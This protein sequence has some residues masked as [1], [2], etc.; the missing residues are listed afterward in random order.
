MKL[1]VFKFGG[2]AVQDAAHIINTASILKQ[3]EGENQ[4]VVI[5]AMGKMTNAFE[6]VYERCKYSRPSVTSHLS[7]LVRAHLKVAEQLGVE[8]DVLLGKYEQHIFDNMFV[9][10][11]RKSVASDLFYDQ[12]VSLGELFSTELVYAYLKSLDMEVRWMDA[13]KVLRTDDTHREGKV[14]FHVSSQKIKKKVK[15]LYKS[16]SV[17]ITQGFIGGTAEGLTTTLG[18]EGSDYTAA[19][20][21]YALGVEELTIWKDVP[22]ILTADPKRFEQVELLKNLSYREAIEMTYYGAKVIHP[23]TIQ[24]IQNKNIKLRVKSF[25]NPK[26]AGTVISSKGQ[27]HYPPIIVIQ[28]EVIL[29]QIASKDFS[30]ISEDHLSFIFDKMKTHKIKLG[31]MRNS[32]ISFTLVILEINEKVL[33]VFV[34]EISSLLTVAI[35]SGLQMLTVRHAQEEGLKSL[36]VGKEILFEET[37]DDTVTMVLK[38][39][40]AF[41]E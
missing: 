37:L 15:Q 27:A 23:K 24:P 3:H 7:K 30:F 10:K 12:V 14:D 38:S 41:K 21:A 16:C 8:T 4:V 29:L 17:V 26:G 5:S 19:I 28:D 31:V 39:S 33:K 13:R 6:Q 35:T 18:R 25:K 32:A 2:A 36:V 22:G 34:K 9:I 11:N 40:L 1:R 20:M